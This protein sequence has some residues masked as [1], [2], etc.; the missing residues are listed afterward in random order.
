M[1]EESAWFFKPSGYTLCNCSKWFF[2]VSTIRVMG[3]IWQIFGK[4]LSTSRDTIRSSLTPFSPILK[5]F[6]ATGH[7]RVLAFYLVMGV[8]GDG[9][10]CFVKRSQWMLMRERLEWFDTDR[11][12]DFNFCF[13]QNN[14]R[15]NLWIY[16][17]HQNWWFCWLCK[18]YGPCSWLWT[19]WCEGNFLMPLFFVTPFVE[20]QQH[21]LTFLHATVIHRVTYWAPVKLLLVLLTNW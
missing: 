2:I 21:V 5:V 20:A 17:N 8:F 19:F 13:D 10:F 3:C 11:L 14:D 12:L 18:L 15:L 6:L 4:S 1:R 16:P 7:F 9:S